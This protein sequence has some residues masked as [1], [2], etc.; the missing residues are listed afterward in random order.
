MNYFPQ[1]QRV[2]KEEA[3]PLKRLTE[4]GLSDFSQLC[5]YLLYQAVTEAQDVQRNHSAEV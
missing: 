5:H 3:N 2:F 1:Q 4:N